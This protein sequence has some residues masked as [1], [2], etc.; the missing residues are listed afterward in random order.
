MLHLQERR[1]LRLFLRRD[2]YGRFMSCMVYLPR[3]RY[4]TQV[5]H[6][7]EEILLEAFDGTSIDYTALV[8]ESVLARL[9]FVVR[10]DQS[11]PVPQVD[12]AQ[13]EARLVL[14]TRSWDDD[15]VDELRGSC[16]VE[17]AA[18]LADVYGEA[19]PEAYK[20]DLPATD[21]VADLHRLEALSD[22]GDIDL[23]LY[24]PDDA[25]AGERRLRLYHVGDPVSLSQV[26]P[27][28]QE[29]GVEVVDE[30]PYEIV[31]RGRR[32][33]WVYDFGLRYEP[34]RRAAG[35]RR[36]DAVPGR[37]RRGLA[38]PRRERRVQRARAARRA[39]LAAGDGPAGLR[40]VPA[41]GRCDVQPALHR[42]V[43]APPTPTWPGC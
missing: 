43:R 28:L 12:P 18:R 39:D 37:V 5:R 19:F 6:A 13:I 1:Q 21:A 33:A 41:A 26:L 10:V 20:E 40:Q 36:P 34:V 27:Q 35:R 38:G 3:D 42:G 31:R 9:H 8:S 22:E 32:T 15:F 23:Y 24:V 30:R 14:A 29:M 25:E 17:T 11:H 16:G 7:M 4:T 2:D